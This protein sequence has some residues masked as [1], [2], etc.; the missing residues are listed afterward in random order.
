MPQL[1][2]P[3]GISTPQRLELG[4]RRL[5]GGLHQ[6]AI[7]RRQSA[8]ARRTRTPAGCRQQAARTIPA[9]GT[10]RPICKQQAAT[11]SRQRQHCS[12]QVGTLRQEGEKE[13]SHV[14]KKICIR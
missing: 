1:Y 6:S 13:H 7:A 8:A 10:D 2:V 3:L 9:A 5:G 11:A 12:L 14:I 4:R